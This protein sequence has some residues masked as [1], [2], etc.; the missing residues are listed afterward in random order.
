MKLAY[1][2]NPTSGKLKNF[3]PSLALALILP[4]T[5]IL[6]TGC[7]NSLT[8]EAASLSIYSPRVLFLK[9]GIPV[10]TTEGIYTPQKNELWHSDAAFVETERRLR[11]ADF[12]IIELRKDAQDSSPK[13]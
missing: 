13:R 11:D 12:Q 6:P 5:L 7:S 3:V 2:M 9:A 10:Q 1:K 8:A 4:A